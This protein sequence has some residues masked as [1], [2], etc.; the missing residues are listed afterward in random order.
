MEFMARPKVIP[1]HGR[2]DALGTADLKK[3]KKYFKIKFFI[4]EKNQIKKI[5][6]L[7]QLKLFL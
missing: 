5:A 1:V 3:K 6:F 4:L 7:K 2:S